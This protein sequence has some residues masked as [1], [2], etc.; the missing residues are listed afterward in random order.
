MIIVA[1][2][3]IPNLGLLP[4]A[5]GCMVSSS[6]PSSSTTKYA[7]FENSAWELPGSL[8]R[9]PPSFG[10]AIRSAHVPIVGGVENTEKVQAA[11]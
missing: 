11:Q 1:S 2:F 7:P 3:V 5:A 10:I 6:G 4:V 9:L 8:K